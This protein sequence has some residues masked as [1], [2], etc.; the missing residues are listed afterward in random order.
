MLLW[1]GGPLPSLQG[2]SEKGAPKES[3]E[4][5]S[6][7]KFDSNCRFLLFYKEHNTP[8]FLYVPLEMAALC[9]T[10]PTS[11]DLTGVGTLSRVTEHVLLEITALCSTIPT[12]RDLTG[13]G[14]LSRVTTHMYLEFAALCSTIATPRK[15]T[16]VFAIHVCLEHSSFMGKRV[17]TAQRKRQ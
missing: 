15:C 1:R 10:I 17:E 7:I 5:P 11:R 9:S 4:N 2:L 14:T 12:P 3:T 6:P 8:L 13:V 16:R